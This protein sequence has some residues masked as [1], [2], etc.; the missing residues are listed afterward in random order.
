MTIRR[1]DNKY[2]VFLLAFTACILWATAFPFLKL[3]YTALGIKPT[4][5]Y[6][7]ML[8]ASYRFFVAGMMLFGFLMLRR[9]SLALP[10]RGLMG[11]M[12][13]LGLLQTSLQYFFFYVGLAH[14]TG[15]KASVM[16]GIG[17]FFAVILAHF[18]YRNDRISWQ[19]VIGLA[20]GFA[21]VLVVNMGKGGLSLDFTWLGEGFLVMSALFSTI[22][23]VVA[24][25]VAG[26]AS[27]VLA[28]A[29]QMIFGSVLLF[30]V[31]VTKVSPFALSFNFYSAALFL[32]LAFLSAQH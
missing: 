20:V 4:D 32:W 6:T 24:K 31:A 5:F 1:L 3:S 12:V 30:G 26:K 27:P 10:Q 16:G 11:S 15:V 29:Y 8:F 28:S 25:D 18:L 22:G 23:S 19:K 17:S 9:E 2:L 7:N 21:G 14:T 13:W